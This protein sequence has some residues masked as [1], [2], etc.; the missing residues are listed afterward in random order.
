MPLETTLTCSPSVVN[1]LKYRNIATAGNEA[2]MGTTYNVY[3]M[4]VGK[5]LE[6]WLLED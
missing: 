1:V 5:S 3:K 4:L 2:L 6:K